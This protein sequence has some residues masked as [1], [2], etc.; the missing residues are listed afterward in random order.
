MVRKK[1]EGARD[2][3][4]CPPGKQIKEKGY[5]KQGCNMKIVKLELY[6]AGVSKPRKIVK[7]SVNTV[8]LSIFL[9]NNVAL[10]SNILGSCLTMRRDFSSAKLSQDILKN[11]QESK[12]HQGESSV[13][14]TGFLSTN[15]Q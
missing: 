7:E 9:R 12:V 13:T 4:H 10:F 8:V 1:K 14:H 6:G 5:D 11:A 2:V 15:S 3:V